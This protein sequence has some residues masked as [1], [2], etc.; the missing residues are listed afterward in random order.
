MRKYYSYIWTSEGGYA[1]YV[2][3]QDLNSGARTLGWAEEM[4]SLQKHKFERNDDKIEYI[5]YG[6]GRTDNKTA[7]CLRNFDGL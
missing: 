1:I 2:F 6:Y 3:G 4:Q 5:L 7:E